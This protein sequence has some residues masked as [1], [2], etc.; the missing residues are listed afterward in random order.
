[1]L[2]QPFLDSLVN[3]FQTQNYIFVHSFIPL[4][5]DDW[6]HAHQKE[7]DDAMWGNPYQLAEQGFLPDKTLVFGHFHTSWP[8]RY[9]EGKPEFADGADFSIYYGNGYIALDACTVH[10][11]HVNVL[12]LDDEF[13]DDNL[14]A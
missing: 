2:V 5:T 7:W 10:S 14:E 9:Y 11:G 8:R 12:V 4:H 13:L 6:R 1:M 3:Y